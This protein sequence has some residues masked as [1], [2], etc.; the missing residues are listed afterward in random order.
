MK[1]HGRAR[2]DMPEFIKVGKK[3]IKLA[4]DLSNK[5]NIS[6]DTDDHYGFV[7]S[8]FIKKQI[9]HFRSIIILVNA[10]QH[11]DCELIARSMI[12]G[13]SLLMF[14][15]EY[16]SSTVKSH[17]YIIE[18]AINC[19][20]NNGKVYSTFSGQLFYTKNSEEA[21]MNTLN[22]ID[23]MFANYT[24][25]FVDSYQDR[26][27]RYRAY[28]VLYDKQLLENMKKDGTYIDNYSRIDI[29]TAFNNFSKLFLTKKAKNCLKEKKDLPENPYLSDWTPKR[30]TEIMKDVLYYKISKGIIEKIA[31]QLKDKEK[32]NRLYK[33]SDNTFKNKEELTDLLNK[34]R[35]DKDEIE[36]ILNIDGIQKFHYMYN[37]LYENFSLWHHWHIGGIVKVYERRDFTSSIK[38]LATGGDCLFFTLLYFEKH[39]KLNYN[40]KIDKLYSEMEMLIDRCSV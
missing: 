20:L 38:A 11:H 26:A 36:I 31:L 30:I 27:F 8:F 34:L 10:N 18:K 35:F 2:K 19:V 1:K 29:E 39:F 5:I 6:P 13:L 32:V 9:E 21:I 25:Y 40:Q 3:I 14:M 4:I 28:S 15:S 22:S 12:E 37:E 23:N 33:I 16:Y 17:G 7:I 24:S